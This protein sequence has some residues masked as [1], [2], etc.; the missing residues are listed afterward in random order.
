VAVTDDARRLWRHVEPIHAVTHFAPEVEGA[1]AALGLRGFWMGYVAARAAPMGAVTAEV[2]TAAF[3]GF[4]PSRTHRAIPDASSIA[5]PPAV[6]A[7]RDGARRARV[8]GG[9]RARG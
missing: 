1:L 5:P 3:Y 7:A 8:I 9:R 6:L 2:V 4:S